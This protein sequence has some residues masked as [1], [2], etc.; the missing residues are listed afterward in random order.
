MEQHEFKLLYAT[1]TN[2]DESGGR[3]PLIEMFGRTREGRSI[4]ALYKGFFP[5]FILIEPEQSTLDALAKDPEVRSLDPRTLFREGKPVTAY[6]VTI[7]RPGDTPTY[8]DRYGAMAAD[9][10]FR[11][12]FLYDNQLGSH[13]RIEGRERAARQPYRTDLVID[14]ERVATADPFLVPL[15][16]LSFDIENLTSGEII[17]IGVVKEYE[18]RT[19]EQILEGSEKSILEKFRKIIVEEDVDVLSGYN[20]CNY[21][22]PVIAGRME[23][24][25][26]STAWAR[27]GRDV[28]I[29]RRGADSRDKQNGGADAGKVKKFVDKGTNTTV[30]IPGRLV[31]DSWYFAR[32]EKRPK[33]ETLGAMAQ[34]ILGKAKMDVDTSKMD[35]EWK[36]RPGLVKEYCLQ[37]TRLSHEILKAIHVLDKYQA[38]ADVAQ[39]PLFD[40]LLDR[41]SILIDSLLIRAADREKVV[42]PNNR[43][44]DDAEAIEGGYVHE[45]KAGLYDNVVVFDF[46]SLYPSVIIQNN[47]CFTTISDQGTI[48]AP[49]GVK[50]LDPSVKEGILPRVMKGLLEARRESKKKMKAAK[51]AEEKAYYN[52]LQ[53]AQ[54]ILANAHYGVF[55]SRFYR[56]TDRR[57]GGSI[58]ALA[59]KY[60]TGIIG[61]LD[62][63]G[64][65]VIYSD[66]D[67]V[68]VVSPENTLEGTL[69][70]AEKLSGRFSS[71]A[72]TLEFEKV[73]S[74]LF[75]GKMKK[76][77]FGRVVHPVREVVVRGFETRR[78]DSFPLLSRSLDAL[79]EKIMDKDVDG[80]G[81]YARQVLKQVAEGSLPLA[82]LVISKTALDESSYKVMTRK[83]GEV[84]RAEDRLPH[85]Q[86]VKKAQ[87]FGVYI[88]AGMKVSWIVTNSRRTPQQVEPYIDG[89]AFSHAPDHLYYRDKLCD[90]FLRVLENF[91]YDRDALVEREQLGLF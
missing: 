75:L 37:D 88:P 91:D 9:I 69:A 20:I 31:V 84:I 8:R 33:R 15:R 71:G 36:T 83:T 67:S 74:P 79:F 4:T 56:F 44:G 90:A 64:L 32:K 7:H 27:N 62:E 61:K 42:V 22:I 82:D 77:Y 59:R 30:E 48:E 50:F 73:V 81:D 58:T 49:D 53:N 14:A 39:L 34:M 43:H 54:K 85:L 70:F 2:R 17:C 29:R 72:L 66:T 55:A 35:E 28:L 12:R 46:A 10:V 68:F 41:N 80:A 65:N 6:K 45:P 16:I 1:Y 60:T 11:N 23:R 19:E 63:E 40:C 5:Y 24:H 47:I 76:R 21:D 78:G 57:I 26:V 87:K 51:T 52:S 89:I 3:F 38:L 86:A 25:G 13:I 18:G